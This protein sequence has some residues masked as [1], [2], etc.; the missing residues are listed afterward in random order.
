MQADGETLIEKQG[1]EV[2]G[3]SPMIRRGTVRSGTLTQPASVCH[4]RGNHLALFIP[5]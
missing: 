1:I 5:S 3:D 2:N 4:S